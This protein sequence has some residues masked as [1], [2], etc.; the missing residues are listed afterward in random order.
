MESVKDNCGVIKLVSLEKNQVFLTD[1]PPMLG[2]LKAPECDKHRFIEGNLEAKLP[3]IWTDGKALKHGRSSDVEMRKGEEYGHVKVHVQ[4]IH[5][6]V[7]ILI[8]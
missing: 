7:S 8:M 2:N 4:N 3:I 6:Y 5:E 1:L